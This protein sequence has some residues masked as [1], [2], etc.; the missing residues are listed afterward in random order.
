MAAPGAEASVEVELHIAGGAIVK[1]TLTPEWLR[2]VQPGG[3]FVAS[4]DSQGGLR[5]AAVA[6]LDWLFDP[7]LRGEHIEVLDGDGAY[8]IIESSAV[9]AVRLVDPELEVGGARNH[10]GFLFPPI[11]ATKPARRAW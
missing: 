8:W 6:A 2:T 5:Q 11:L 3:A 1:W 7:K 4:E 9:I 10:A